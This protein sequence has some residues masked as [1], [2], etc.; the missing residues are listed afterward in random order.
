VV[1]GET[2]EWYHYVWMSIPIVL[3]FLG[4]AI[5]GLCGGLA[6]GMSSRVFRSDRAEGTKYALT[7]LISLAAFFTYFVVAGTIM[8][9]M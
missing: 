5:G 1:V 9:A 8:T 4:G 7:G 3:V 2:L 6:A